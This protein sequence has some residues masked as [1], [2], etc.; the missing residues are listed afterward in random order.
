M[1]GFKQM[2]NT[3]EQQREKLNAYVTAMLVK[4]LWIWYEKTLLIAT[5]AKLICTSYYRKIYT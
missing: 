2:K 4:L 1:V 5:T 3:H